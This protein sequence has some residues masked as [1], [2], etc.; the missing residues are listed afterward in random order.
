[1]RY[2]VGRDTSLR[3]DSGATSLAVGLNFAIFTFKHNIKVI[4]NGHLRN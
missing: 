2:E 1:M 4:Q 3:L